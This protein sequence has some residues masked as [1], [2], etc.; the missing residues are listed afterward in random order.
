MTCAEGTVEVKGHWM[1]DGRKSF[2]PKRKIAVSPDARELAL[3]MK[4]ARYGGNPEHKR[5]PGDFSLTPPSNPRADK[6]LCDAA[7][8][9]SRHV[10]LKLLLAGIERGLVSLQLRKGYPQNIWSVTDDG[11]PLEAQL[12]NSD[13]ETATYHGYPMADSDP[14][15]DVIVQRWNSA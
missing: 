7:G 4:S 11:I 9:F 1:F 13:G 2:N 15:R 14:F 12:E 10:A 6:T 3:W 8:I 5:N